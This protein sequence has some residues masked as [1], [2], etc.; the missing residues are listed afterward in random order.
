MKETKLIY[1][2]DHL[3]R[4]PQRWRSQYGHGYYA[5]DEDKQKIQRG[6]DAL[7]QGKFTADEADQ[8]IGNKSWSKFECDICGHDKDVLLRMGDE[9]DYEARWLDCCREC[10]A[11]SIRK[12]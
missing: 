9:P 11:L 3:D 4:I 8:I 7:P 2:R 5:N 1:K 12:F 10:L 6:L